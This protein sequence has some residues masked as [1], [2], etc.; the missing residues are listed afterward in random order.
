MHSVDESPGIYGE[1]A[2]YWQTIDGDELNNKDENTEYTDYDYATV[3]ILK[4]SFSA[5]FSFT[6]KVL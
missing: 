6:I 2:D 5:H 1:I 4:N 3:M